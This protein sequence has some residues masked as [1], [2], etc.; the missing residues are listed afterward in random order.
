MLGSGVDHYGSA[1]TDPVDEATAKKLVNAQVLIYI[2]GVIQYFDVFGDYHET[3]FCYERVLDSNAFIGCEF[4]N[5]FDK[6]PEQH[7]RK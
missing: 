6:R 1:P 5:W 3:G 2:Y 4:G 7:C